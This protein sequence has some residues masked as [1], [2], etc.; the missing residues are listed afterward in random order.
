MT[1]SPLQSSTATH[2]S[3]TTASSAIAN[4]DKQTVDLAH[5]WYDAPDNF[6]SNYT[7]GAYDDLPD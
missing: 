1:P 5:P 3:G 2:D 6:G 7:A 4:P